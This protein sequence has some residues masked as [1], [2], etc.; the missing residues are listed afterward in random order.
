MRNDFIETY[1]GKLFSYTDTKP[2]SICVED[3]AHHLSLICRFTGACREFYSVAEH[4]LRV[5]YILP[6]KLKLAGLLHDAHEAYTGD[7]NRPMKTRYRMGG[8]GEKIQ[9]VICE[10]YDAAYNHPDVKVA[11]N[12]L[13]RT[14]ADSLMNIATDSAISSFWES[15]PKALPEKIIPSSSDRI[16]TEFIIAFFM[17]G[18]VEQ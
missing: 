18:G 8:I 14:E 15:L 1:T 9:K 5:S 16:R 12:I 13:L 2:D 7:L 17:Y 10:K 3:I 6:E 11:D 4:S